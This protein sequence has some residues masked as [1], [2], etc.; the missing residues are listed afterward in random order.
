M[1]NFVANGNYIR[2][3][4]HHRKIRRRSEIPESSNSNFRPRFLGNALTDW[5]SDLQTKYNEWISSQ[6]AAGNLAQRIPEKF[7]TA[8]HLIY[9][10]YQIIG[11]N[12]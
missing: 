9:D 11:M 6:G 5:G 3:L 12:Y 2:E 4:V 1:S 7:S 8:E 10:D